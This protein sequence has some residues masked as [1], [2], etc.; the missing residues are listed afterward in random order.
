MARF[1]RKGSCQHDARLPPMPCQSLIIVHGKACRRSLYYYLRKQARNRRYL[2]TSIEPS[3]IIAGCLHFR[4]ASDSL[5]R[6]SFSFPLGFPFAFTS[7]HG[8]AMLSPQ[9][10]QAPS[11][12]NPR[13]CA[14]SSPDA[15]LTKPI[16]H[17]GR[18]AEWAGGSMLGVPRSQPEP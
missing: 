11:F 10:H 13:A 5:S 2:N 3:I 1:K 8:C 12:R 7:S 9:L 17:E 4:P 14:F 6:C 18:H 16:G 15:N